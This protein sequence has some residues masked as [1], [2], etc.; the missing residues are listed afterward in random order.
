MNT[1]AVFGLIVVFAALMMPEGRARAQYEYSPPEQLDD[2]WAVASVTDVGMN[3]ET[4]AKLTN[5]LLDGEFEGV[6][7][8]IIV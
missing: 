1:G 5:K 2:G 7:S 8:M 3:E 6:H 4:I